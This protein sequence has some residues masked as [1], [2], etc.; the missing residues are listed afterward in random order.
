MFYVYKDLLKEEDT[1]KDVLDNFGNV[2]GGILGL[3]SGNSDTL[4][5]T[6]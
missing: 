3:T 6:I 4:S 5:S 1:P 2:L